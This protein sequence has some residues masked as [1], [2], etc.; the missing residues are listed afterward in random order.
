MSVDETVSTSE[1][2]AARPSE[3]RTERGPELALQLR[4]AIRPF[5]P[6]ASTRQERLR[7]VCAGPAAAQMLWSG[8]AFDVGRVG[9][10]RARPPRTEVCSCAGTGRCRTIG[11]GRR[12]R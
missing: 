10:L 2:A 3:A 4:T 5:E 6:K 9:R 1:L 12:R 8:F 7:R 11:F